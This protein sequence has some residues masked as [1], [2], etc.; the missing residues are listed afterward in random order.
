LVVFSKVDTSL[1]CQLS[2]F[3]KAILQL[4]TFIK[5]HAIN[6]PNEPFKFMTRY[7]IDIDIFQAT[8]VFLVFGGFLGGLIFNFIKYHPLSYLMMLAGLIMAIN[9]LMAQS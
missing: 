3:L 7:F 4:F 5:K 1:L 8:A 2:P 9:Q 6:W